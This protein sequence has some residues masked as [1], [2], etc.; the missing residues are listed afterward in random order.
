M[1]FIYAVVIAGVCAALPI[2]W[3]FMNALTYA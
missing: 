3:I 1:T 2:V